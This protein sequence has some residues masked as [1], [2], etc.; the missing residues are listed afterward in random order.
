MNMKR[1]LLI[2]GMIFIMVVVQPLRKVHESKKSR[3][4][5]PRGRYFSGQ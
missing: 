3:N 1:R 2:P 5:R 4:Y